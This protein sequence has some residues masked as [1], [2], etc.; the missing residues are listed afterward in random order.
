MVFIGGGVLANIMADKEHMWLT[1][2]EWVEGGSQS[3]A[4]FGPR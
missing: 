1:Q 3:L 4:K 2:E